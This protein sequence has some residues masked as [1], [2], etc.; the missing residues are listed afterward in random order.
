VDIFDWM[1]FGII[2]IGVIVVYCA[3]RL[4]L[5]LNRTFPNIIWWIFPLL[6]IWAWIN[7]V[8]VFWFAF[9]GYE[10]IDIIASLN[11]IWWVGIAIG[12][13]KFRVA[14]ESILPKCQGQP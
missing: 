9:K 2:L 5:V 14:A 3:F 7:R 13:H 4:T 6:M 8:M 1:N 11:I 12:I 10:G